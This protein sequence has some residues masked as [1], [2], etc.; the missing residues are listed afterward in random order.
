M[1]TPL[2]IW[3][4]RDSNNTASP[5]IILNFVSDTLAINRVGGK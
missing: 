2:F 3:H 4:G 5:G 1:R